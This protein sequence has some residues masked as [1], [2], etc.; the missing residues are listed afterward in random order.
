MRK[1]AERQLPIEFAFPQK[2]KQM[3]EY[4]RFYKAM[5]DILDRNPAILDAVHKDLEAGEKK[6]KR[7]V[8]GVSSETVLRLIV[9]QQAEDLSFRD[10]MTRVGDSWMLCFFVRVYDDP[11]IYYST[12]NKLAN[13]ITPESGHTDC[14]AVCAKAGS[15]IR[16]TLEREFSRTICPGWQDVDINE[17]K[18]G[19]GT[20]SDRDTPSNGG[21][22]RHPERQ[23][24]RHPKNN[25]PKPPTLATE[26]RIGNGN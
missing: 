15:T 26:L 6:L 13:C 14:G 3:R 12:F 16:A 2:K 8:E 20:K 19:G 11:L 25:T 4:L 1:K 5:S 21:E 10:L 7:N 9:V 17:R 22:N 18:T 24:V 23:T